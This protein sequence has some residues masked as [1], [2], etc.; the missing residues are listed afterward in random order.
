[1]VGCIVPRHLRNEIE[2]VRRQRA[3]RQVE[4]ARAHLCACYIW[5]AADCAPG[6]L[7][8]RR[9]DGASV[10]GR[11]TRYVSEQRIADLLETL[12]VNE[13]ARVGSIGSGVGE[14]VSPRNLH[15]HLDSDIG[16][17]SIDG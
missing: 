3:Q 10:A 4:A 13:A 6:A 17:R 14:H 11:A 12:V 9:T 2:A 5:R 15:A 7:G 8:V 16:S 1:M